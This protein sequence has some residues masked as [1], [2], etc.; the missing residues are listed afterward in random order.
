MKQSQIISVKSLTETLARA[1]QDRRYRHKWLVERCKT[2]GSLAQTH[3]PELNIN[4]MSLN[5]FKKYADT[6]ID[7][8]F[9]LIDKLR[10]NVLEKAEKTKTTK[11]EKSDA[12][13]KKV[14]SLS[15]QLELAQKQK[16]VLQKAYFELNEIALEAIANSPHR[17]RLLD[18]HNELYDKYFS[19]H[20]VDD[21]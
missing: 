19:L 16:A 2:Q 7:G 4:P 9:Q 13:S 12:I 5:T 14:R 18:R 6:F 1:T 20:V 10:L 3:K 17:K 21:E 8:G 15:F 11:Q